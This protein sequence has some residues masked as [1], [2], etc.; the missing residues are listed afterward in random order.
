VAISDTP[1]GSLPG[2]WRQTLVDPE[3]V[4]FAID[5]HPFVIMT[6]SGTCFM[7]A[8]SLM[9]TRRRG[10]GTALVADRLVSMTQLSAGDR[11]PAGAVSV[12]AV[13]A[14]PDHA[15]LRNRPLTG[16]LLKA[17]LFSIMTVV[18]GVST[19]VRPMERRIMALIMGSGRVLG[20]IPT[21]V[22]T[23]PA[24][25]RTTP[26]VSGAP[27]TTRSRSGRMAASTSFFMPGMPLLQAPDVCAASGMDCRRA[28]A[29]WG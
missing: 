8:I 19:A 4:P 6:G 29:F 20:P 16:I 22:R 7:R 25:L 27:A 12:A 18:T 26:V 15:R 21:P 24:F 3:Q 28:R 5:A 2:L 14:G 17:P 11:D 1:Q 23:R 9:R 13:S 10:Q